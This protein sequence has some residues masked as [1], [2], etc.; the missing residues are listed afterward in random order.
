MAPTSKS[1]QELSEPLLPQSV[2]SNT[3]DATLEG[4][5]LYGVAYE[6]FIAVDVAS[7]ATSA[8][9][10]FAPAATPRPIDCAAVSEFLLH[11]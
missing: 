11:R 5:A 2:K 9:A 7:P 6:D 8:V 4:H 3:G 10:N 1:A